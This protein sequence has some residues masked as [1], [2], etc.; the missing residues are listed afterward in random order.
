[1]ATYS[2]TA[3][4]TDSVGHPSRE[5][6][7]HDDGVD[8]E[9]EPSTFGQAVTFT[10]TVTAGANPVTTGTVTSLTGRRPWSASPSRRGSATFTTLTL[11]EPH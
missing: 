9:P 2:G 7:G 1:M 3:A 8:L 4:F 10:A 6:G 5:P 11:T